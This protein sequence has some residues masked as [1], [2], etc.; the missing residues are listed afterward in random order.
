MVFY[1]TFG[2]VRAI[3]FII[4]KHEVLLLFGI[5]LCI[6]AKVEIADIKS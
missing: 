5:L 4:S 3:H 1:F 2:H 6:I